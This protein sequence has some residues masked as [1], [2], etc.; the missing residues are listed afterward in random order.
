MLRLYYLKI[1]LSRKF[2]VRDKKYA[3]HW[4]RMVICGL[5]DK[6]LVRTSIEIITIILPIEIKI[7]SSAIITSIQMF[8][9]NSTGSKRIISEY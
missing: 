2:P 5:G 8:P 6:R 9:I 4:I 1:H 3:S 7:I